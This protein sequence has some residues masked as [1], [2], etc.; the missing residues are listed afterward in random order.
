[1]A[2]DWRPAIADAGRGAL[3][4]ANGE[5]SS[6]GSAGFS[7]KMGCLTGLAGRTSAGTLSS[8]ATT[9]VDFRCAT[10]F[11]A[12]FVVG[13][14]V[15]SSK[16]SGDL[17]ADWVLDTGV[18]FGKGGRLEI[19]DARDFVWVIEAKDKLLFDTVKLL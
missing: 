6:S 19:E 3:F 7:K 5:R 14:G 16:A 12:G 13:V 8:C 2:L 4:A 10:R 17:I 18:G 15:V 9:F 1:M 11:L